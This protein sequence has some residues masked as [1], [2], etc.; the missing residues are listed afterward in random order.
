[1]ASGIENP[2]LL[3][4]YLFRRHADNGA[5]TIDVVDDIDREQLYFSLVRVAGGDA[6]ND[7]VVTFRDAVH[8]RFRG[9]RVLKTG[10]PFF[11]PG[12]ETRLSLLRGSSDE[13]PG[14]H[15]VESTDIATIIEEHSLGGFTYWSN[16][17]GIRAFYT[18]NANPAGC[19]IS[20]S[21]LEVLGLRPS[22]VS[23]RVPRLDAPALR[24]LFLQRSV[25]DEDGNRYTRDDWER[26]TLQ[27]LGSLTGGGH[28]LAA[29]CVEGE[30][31]AELA[32]GIFRS[33]DA[34]GRPLFPSLEFIVAEH[35]LVR[36]G[37][38]VD[39]VEIGCCHPERITRETRGCDEKRPDPVTFA[40]RELTRGGAFS[41][42]VANNL[43]LHS[44]DPR[45]AGL[46]PYGELM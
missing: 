17:D 34:R 36:A 15:G 14:H 9:A 37:R 24:V 7:F 31:S 3:H 39:E 42:L 22:H 23:K 4:I 11:T 10:M 27:A 41:H 44:V 29:L 2:D 33:A 19:T 43:H 5:D 40:V 35:L 30:I 13:F 6:P 21:T 26:I 18:T 8:E 38:V 20:S 12:A 1:M 25:E 16:L 32:L 46:A 28:P 45:D